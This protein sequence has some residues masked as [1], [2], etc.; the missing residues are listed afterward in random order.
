VRVTIL[1]VALLLLAATGAWARTRV[2]IVLIDA[3]DASFVGEE[4]TPR[5]WQLATRPDA[6]GAF[7]PHAQAIMPSVTNPNHAAVMTGTYA[8]AHGIVGNLLWDRVSESP[9]RSD[10]NNLEVE[11]LF[12][13]VEKERPALTTAGVFGKARLVAL[14]GN[15]S[16]RQRGPDVL[17]GDPQS[18]DEAI[19]PRTGFASDER[20]MSEALRVIAARDPDLLFVAL[21]DVDRTA[22]IFGPLSN[23]ARRA[24]L[25]ADRQLGRLV[26]ATQRQGIW[27]HLVLMVTADHGMQSVEP[28]ASRPYPIVLF[29]RE[30][31]RAGLTGVRPITSGGVEFV[32]LAGNAPAALDHAQAERLRAVRALALAQPEIAEA[33]YRLP[34]PADGGD[35]YTLSRAHP[36]WRLAH[37]RA[38]ELVLVAVPHCFF[39]DPFTPHLGGLAGEHGGPGQRDIAILLTGG[40]PRLGRA[41]GGGTDDRPAANPDLG[42]TAAWL[43]GVRAPR[44]VSGQPVGDELRGRILREAFR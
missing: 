24:V 18:E 13:V 14:F 29:G 17:W 27:D 25:E 3:L 16:G 42:Q 10:G 32:A 30:L 15:V 28:D 39:A 31:T 7:Y 40:D 23:Q 5:L 34:N 33:W 37:P 11:T 9:A 6:R 22:H 43:L 44:F 36:D 41:V 20:T 35:A 38:G 12:T 21:P 8:A 26:D 19:D 1:L 4:L 2:Y